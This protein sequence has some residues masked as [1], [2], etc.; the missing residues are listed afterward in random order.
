MKALLAL[1]FALC[2]ATAFAAEVRNASVDADAGTLS[3][4]VVYGGG[5]KEHKFSLKL[6]GCMESMPVQCSAKL[7]DSVYDDF[8]EA[9]IHK[10]VVISLKK[11]GLVGDYY[12]QGSLRIKGDAE[13]SAT[14]RLP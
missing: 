1:C 14:V 8:C 5:C 2:T 4:D 3:I 12:A 13:T 7:V 6:E 11:V 10:T 9:L